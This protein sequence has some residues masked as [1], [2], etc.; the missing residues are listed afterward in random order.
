[1]IGV[2]GINRPVGQDELV[3][4]TPTY[5]QYLRASEKATVVE[6][7]DV[8]LPVRVS[9]EMTGKAS[10][11]APGSPKRAIPSG[12]VVLTASGAAAEWLKS[13]VHA[14]D[15]LRFRFDLISNPLPAGPFRGNLPSRAATLR[16]RSYKSV[17]TDIDQAIGGGPWLVRDG[18]AAIDAEEEKIDRAFASTRNPRTAAGVSVAGELLIL[19]ID[20]RQP[21]SRG[22]SLRE[23]AEYLI[24]QGALNAINLDGG[25]SS[26][27][28]IR[29]LYVNGPSDGE[30]RP[31]ADALL[32]LQDERT[33]AAPVVPMDILTAISLKAGETRSILFPLLN[34]AAGTGQSM[35]GTIEGRGYVSQQ[36]ALT[37]THAG[38]GTVVAKTTGNEYRIPYTIEPGPP[39][40]ITAVFTAAPNNP[41]D[42]SILTVKVADRFGNRVADQIVTVK[43]I[44]G[45]AER[46]NLK[47]DGT[48]KASIEIV[49]DVEVA[50][51]VTVTSGSFI[52]ITVKSK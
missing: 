52:P 47:T 8:D 11:P 37:G 6:L 4:L 27:M 50:R 14:G 22:M 26:T 3:L 29:D 51:S 42:R 20:G 23:L 5:G 44:G 32:V 38:S 25:G 17:W 30:P 49:W 1:L 18:K 13:H 12:G 46:D 19:T 15:S 7:A 48:G 39:S 21:H 10:E 45:T 16:G 33:P 36:G 40:K 35:Y 9:K 34:G 2:D 31:I 28:V 41:P 24:Q 43:V